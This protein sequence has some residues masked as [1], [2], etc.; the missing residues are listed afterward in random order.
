MP[1]GVEKI[2]TLC[3][4]GKELHLTN[5]TKQSITFAAGTTGAID[6]K[7]LF[8]VTG[9]VLCTIIGYVTTS[10]TSGGAATIQ[11]GSSE[12][13]DLIAA[14]DSFDDW[15][16]GMIA[17]NGDCDT[18]V[19][20]ASVV[21]IFVNEYDLGY[22]ISAATITGGAVDFYCLWTPISEDG[23]VVAAGSNVDL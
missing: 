3:S 1:P 10:L 16:A 21:W 14:A 7:E 23:D 9:T 15:D 6:A 4:R 2:L 20:Y 12:D 13:T 17:I 5:V 11:L 22:E 19:N 8:T 18:E